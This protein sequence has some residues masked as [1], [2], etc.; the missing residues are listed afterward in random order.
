[1]NKCINEYIAK[2]EEFPIVQGKPIYKPRTGY[3]NS[4]M[5]RHVVFK[6]V[7]HQ[8]KLTDE[9]RDNMGIGLSADRTKFFITNRNKI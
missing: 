6:H 7:D 9:K 4:D 1:M 5:A 3:W 8:G 2:T